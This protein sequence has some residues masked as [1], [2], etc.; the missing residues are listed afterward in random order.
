MSHDFHHTGKQKY[1]ILNINSLHVLHI[2]K[3]IGILPKNMGKGNEIKIEKAHN[4]RY[5]T[6]LM[7]MLTATTQMRY[8]RT[9][10]KSTWWEGIKQM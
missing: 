9:I 5:L 10:W 1:C 2:T 3:H 6:S 7:T 4:V 8:S